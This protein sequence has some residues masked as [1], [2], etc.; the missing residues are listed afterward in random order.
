MFCGISATPSKKVK[1]MTDTLCRENA[2]LVVDDD[3][4]MANLMQKQLSRSG[5]QAVYVNSGHEAV[6]WIDNHIPDLMLLD[7]QL[8]DMTG[9]Q[10]VEELLR[11]DRHIPFILVTGRGDE[12]LAVDMMK[13]GARDYLVKDHNFLDLLPSVVSQTLSQINQEHRLAQAEKALRESETQYHAIFDA[14]GDALFVLDPEAKIIQANPQAL[15]L[16]GYSQDEFANLSA[17]ELLHT[18]YQHLFEQMRL[19]VQSSGGFQSEAVACQ[20]DGTLVDIELRSSTFIHSSRQHMLVMIRDISERKWAEEEL[21]L[22]VQ[23]LKISE[24]A[25]REREARLRAIFQGS[26]IGIALVDLGGRALESN[27]A[28]QEM[29]GYNK[30]ELRKKVFTDFTHPANQSDSV[31]IF[32]KMVRGQC[33]HYQLENRL[34]R[35]NGA[36]VWVRLTASLVR[37][38]GGKPNYI[39]NMVEDVSDRQEALRQLGDKQRA[40]ATLMD[41]LPGIAFRCRND[42]QWTM[43]FVSEG[44]LVLTGY[45]AQQIQDNTEISYADLIVEEDREK[46]WDEIQQA[47]AQ[48]APYKIS[49]RIKTISGQIKWVW[50]RGRAICDESME[51]VAL[52]GFITDITERKHAED[53]A[54][55]GHDQYHSLFEKMRNGFAYHEI[56]CDDTGEPIDYVFLEVNEVFEDLC[57]IK[58]DRL[59]GKRVKEIQE[60][61]QG[62]HHDWLDTYGKVALTGQS[63]EFEHFSEAHQRWFRI[64][65]YSPQ[66]GHFVTVL[67]DIHDRRMVEEEL[68]IF[69]LRLEQSNRDLDQFAHTACQCL[70]EPLN[71]LIEDCRQTREYLRETIDSGLEKC[72]SHMESNVH[73]VMNVTEDLW[74][75]ARADFDRL[76]FEPADLKELI[77]Q[78]ARELGE[79]F[80]NKFSIE[81]ENLP[82]V[83]CDR[84]LVSQL[85]RCLLSNSWSLSYPQ[86][87]T[88][89][90]TAD[91]LDNLW[92]ITFTDQGKG[93]APEHHDK[94]FN[95]FYQLPDH[96]CPNCGGI[97]LAIA[98]K[99]RRKARRHDIPPI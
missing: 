58:R 34:V 66:E 93:I 47:I 72:L 53:Q 83:A 26:A 7:Y 69:A 36:N 24:Q 11:H 54:R 19:G 63:V 17:R 6:D 81:Q 78:A 74:R 90:I 13:Q 86:K 82:T 73:Q 56:V 39:I 38:E 61:T 29:L 64:S 99:N 46:V 35:K 96:G 60:K 67:E 50:E 40:M 44:C 23:Q 12:K 15:R 79:D 88:I 94:I 8:S 84:N 4:G 48:R 45:T 65:A 9:S 68:R 3:S 2:I 91:V 87:S 95:M 70:K 28:L 92:Q 52:E 59:I 89:K 55:K 37:G 75:Y 51:V 32:A 5:M 14:A 71:N 25:L 22:S 30:I 21:N 43:E 49:Y 62:F 85:F 98:Q 76:K 27:R 41:N 16:Y 57:G 97:G 18:D 1:L 31:S 10:V 77:N 80:L 33:D 42:R 20:K